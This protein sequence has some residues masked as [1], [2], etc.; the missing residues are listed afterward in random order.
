MKIANKKGHKIPIILTLLMLVVIISAGL[1][2]VYRSSNHNKTDESLTSTQKSGGGITSGKDAK[3]ASGEPAPTPDSNIVPTIPTGT[4]VSNHRPNLSGSPAPNTIA[5][6]CTTTPGS[7][8]TIEFTR[9]D[10]TKS[11][12]KKIADENGNTSWDWKLQDI[13]L[14]VGEWQVVAIASNGDNEIKA[15]D[16]MLLIVGE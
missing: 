1:F 8:C 4:F 3:G 9:G 5:S 7:E 15:S 11:L 10:T 16:S 14:T 12:P 13:G 6:T 2:Y